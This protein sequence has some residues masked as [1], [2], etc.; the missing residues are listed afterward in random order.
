MIIA[1]GEY[2]CDC[3]YVPNQVMRQTGNDPEQIHFGST[4]MRLRD[5]E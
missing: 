4:L 2:I 3:L 5:G 1:E